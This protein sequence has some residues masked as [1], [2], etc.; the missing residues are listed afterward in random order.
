MAGETKITVIGNLVADPE[1]MQTQNG[2]S[3]ARF[4]IASTSRFYNSKTGEAREESLF[5][6]CVAWR[7]IADNMG[8]SLSK[9]M[10][11]IAQGDL[12]QNDWEDKDGNKRSSLELQIDEIGPSLRFATAS[13]E[14]T[15]RQGG[16]GSPFAAPN[17]VQNQP[18]QRS[19]PMR[20]ESSGGSAWSSGGGS[21]DGWAN[22][23]QSFD[24]SEA[25]F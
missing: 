3:Y 13:V 8:Q 7:E 22:P 11:V 4:T 14:R 16:G 9:G 19:E 2:I 23:G 25:P 21:N 12:K 15:P 24:N 5:M 18:Q 6:R 10:R 1:V 17:Q 20:Q